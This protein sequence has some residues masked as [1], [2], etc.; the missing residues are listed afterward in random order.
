MFIPLD[1]FT[2]SWIFNIFNYLFGGKLSAIILLTAPH[3]TFSFSLLT[4]LSD[5]GSLNDVHNSLVYFL[6]KS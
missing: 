6:T 1:I 4:L 3:V 5:L 2:E